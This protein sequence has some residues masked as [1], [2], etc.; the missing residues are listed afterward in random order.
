MVASGNSGSQSAQLT[1]AFC[2]VDGGRFGSVETVT[3]EGIV[4]VQVPPGVS[5]Q[6]GGVLPFEAHD[7]T[8]A[9]MVPLPALFEVWLT[10]VQSN[11]SEFTLWA[12]REPMHGGCSC[13]LISIA[14]RSRD[15]AKLSTQI[16][17]TADE[18]ALCLYE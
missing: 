7:G 1:V 9:S 2:A 13:A 14:M 3:V 6:Q 18:Q 4:P 11:S 15:A 8:V 16:G 12:T 5:D 17:S 10:T